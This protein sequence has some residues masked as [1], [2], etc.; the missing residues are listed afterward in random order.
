MYF[1]NIPVLL[2]AALTVAGCVSLPKP[3]E[4]YR[5][6]GAGMASQSPSLARREVVRLL[7]EASINS[8]EATAKGQSSALGARVQMLRKEVRVTGKGVEA[9][10]A[11]R[12]IY[13]GSDKEQQESISCPFSN[14]PSLG[15]AEMGPDMVHNRRLVATVSNSAAGGTAKR[16]DLCLMAY[17]EPDE[18]DK[19]IRLAD[20]LY[21]LA[22]RPVQSAAS[23]DEQA[24]RYRE[25]P[26]KPVLSEETIKYKAQAEFAVEQKRFD[27]A[28]DYFEAALEV[29]PWWPEGHFNRA[30]ILG[31]LSRYREAVTEMKNYLQL[32]PNAPDARAAQNKIYQ[33]ESMPGGTASH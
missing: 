32:V 3:V 28:A 24:R 27:D 21:F 29:S 10:L 11:W 22:N 31:E 6:Q 14:M 26:V 20:L 9:L 8:Y 7:K 30:L 16:K 12:W 5:P 23:F 33:W 1:G 25:M 4:V 2:A 19:A 17:F 13:L 18:K 15:V